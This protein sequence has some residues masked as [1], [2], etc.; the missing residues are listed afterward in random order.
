MINWLLVSLLDWLM[1]KGYPQ[2]HLQGVLPLRV[3][4][5]G[6]L[7]DWLIDWLLYWLLDWFMIKG[8]PPR[9]LQRVLP[10][11]V[12]PEGI[13]TDWLIALLIYWLID[14]FIDW[15]RD[16]L[17]DIYNGCSPRLSTLKGATTV[18]AEAMANFIEQVSHL[19]LTKWKLKK[20]GNLSYIWEPI[21]LPRFY[22]GVYCFCVN[23]HVCILWMFT[24]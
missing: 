3:H 16:I 6:S 14:W 8:C 19:N 9:Y 5:E 20:V 10:K 18:Y 24:L 21:R 17:H 1:I 7:T 11:S 22:I 15:L 23:K 4:P 13:L 2:R 12:D